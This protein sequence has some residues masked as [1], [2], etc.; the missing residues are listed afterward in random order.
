M[1]FLK[2]HQYKNTM[3]PGTEIRSLILRNDRHA[4]GGH[5]RFMFEYDAG[6]A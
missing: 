4:G 3:P 2:Q 5:I 1:N 6:V